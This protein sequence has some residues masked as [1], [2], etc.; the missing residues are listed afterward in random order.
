MFLTADSLPFASVI[1]H[2]HDVIAWECDRVLA[3]TPLWRE[4]EIYDGNWQVFVFYDYETGA[5]ERQ[6]LSTCPATARILDSIPGRRAASF[7]ILGARSRVK[8]HVGLEHGVLRLHYGIRVPH[9]CTL[10][11]MCDRPGLGLGNLRSSHA[12]MSAVTSAPARLHELGSVVPAWLANA[13]HLSEAFS[14]EPQVVASVLRGIDEVIDDLA[15]PN[16]LPGL[17]GSCE[18]YPHT[19]SWRTIMDEEGM[20]SRE[21]GTTPHVKISYPSQSQLIRWLNT[22]VVSEVLFPDAF[23]KKLTFDR[24]T[25]VQGEACVFNDAYVHEARNDSDE[26]RAVLLV[27]FERDRYGSA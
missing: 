14:S 5:A 27:D 26:P 8:P 22:A 10:S 4:T 12:L 16:S 9:A 1:A 24:R 2:N 17:W 20:W 18:R 3:Q 23:E 11:A 19:A 15:L 13:I 7:S 25:L 6:N 21:G